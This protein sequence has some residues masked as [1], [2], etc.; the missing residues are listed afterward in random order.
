MT[1]LETPVAAA[2]LTSVGFPV[3]MRSS[4]RSVANRRTLSAVAVW[5][6]G[7]GEGFL[8]GVG[9]EGAT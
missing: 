9:Q 2:R 7:I 6:E 4:R 5:D 8:V 1:L 3:W